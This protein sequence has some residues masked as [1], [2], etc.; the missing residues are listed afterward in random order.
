MITTKGYCAVDDVGKAQD[1][2]QRFAFNFV[3]VLPPFS[4]ALQSRG[5]GRRICYDVVHS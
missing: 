5:R 3:I 2:M 1:A 4:D